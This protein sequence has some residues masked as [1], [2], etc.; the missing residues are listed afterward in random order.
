[1]LRVTVRE[2]LGKGK[3]TE[4]NTKTECKGIDSTQERA[5]S[6]ARL[7]H[8]KQQRRPRQRPG[9]KRR[10]QGMPNQHKTEEKASG[11]AKPAQD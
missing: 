6:K 8:G 9:P 7:S 3:N 11:N 5:T 2:S 1:M 10:P 4:A